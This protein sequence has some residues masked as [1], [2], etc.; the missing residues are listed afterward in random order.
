MG[1]IILEVQYYSL[2]GLYADTKPIYVRNSSGLTLL[3]QT[4][5]YVVLL[6]CALRVGNY[7]H[8]T[9]RFNP[10]KN[11]LKEQPVTLKNLLN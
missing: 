7:S 1:C 6:Q 2:I 8:A 3:R 4:Q 10:L 9:R 11:A 5:T